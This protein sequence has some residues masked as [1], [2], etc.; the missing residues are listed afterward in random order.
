MVTTVFRKKFPVKYHINWLNMLLWGGIGGLA[1]EH[2]AH[3]EII[4]SFPFLTA[5][6]AGNTMEMLAEMGTIGGAMLAACIGIW[7]VMIWFANN[8]MA[9]AGA[10]AAPQ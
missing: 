7:L 5:V 1:L 6:K 4:G 9:D 10:K 3:G 2:V 8:H